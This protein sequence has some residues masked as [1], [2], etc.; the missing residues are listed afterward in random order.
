MGTPREIWVGSRRWFEIFSCGSYVSFH[1][2]IPKTKCIFCFNFIFFS[3]KF[4]QSHDQVFN[5][6]AEAVVEKFLAQNAKWFCFI[7][8]FFISIM[9][10]KSRCSVLLLTDIPQAQL[11]AKVFICFYLFLVLCILKYILLLVF[12]IR[13]ST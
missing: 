5:Y 7:G 13:R 3:V 10:K 1:Y 12:Y 9:Q 6:D 2:F 4:P 8:L 11:F